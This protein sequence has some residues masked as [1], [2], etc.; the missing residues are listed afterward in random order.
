[1]IGKIDGLKSRLKVYNLLNYNLPYLLL[2]DLVGLIALHIN[3]SYVSNNVFFVNI[4]AF[5]IE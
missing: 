3:K 1:M 4:Y 2:N 5:V